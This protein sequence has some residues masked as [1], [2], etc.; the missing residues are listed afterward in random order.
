MKKRFT[1]EQ[2][3]AVTPEHT[4]GGDH[5]IRILDSIVLWRSGNGPFPLW[6]RETVERDF[7]R[8]KHFRAGVF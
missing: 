6:L 5:L 4:I 7:F 3:M 1:E 8:Q 2:I